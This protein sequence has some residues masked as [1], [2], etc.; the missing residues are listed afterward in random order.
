MLLSLSELDLKQSKNVNFDDVLWRGDDG[1]DIARVK[2][3]GVEDDQHFKVEIIKITNPPR[4]PINVG[5]NHPINPDF[6]FVEVEEKKYVC[7]GKTINEQDVKKIDYTK[8]IWRSGKG[9]DIAIVKK[10]GSGGDSCLYA[11]IIKI[12]KDPGL[13]IQ[14]EKT[15]K[16]SVNNLF[17]EI[18]DGS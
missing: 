3:L 4:Y 16:I 7:L 10:I 1:R 8:L 5:D 17:A 18:A 13:A 9:E 6:L 12:I 2:V 15:M 14:V 11:K